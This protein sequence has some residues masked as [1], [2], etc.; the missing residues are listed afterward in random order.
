MGRF[1]DVDLRTRRSSLRCPHCG[2]MLARL[3]TPPSLGKS[4]ELNVWVCNS[5]DHTLRLEV[6]PDE[7]THK[8]AYL[9][10]I[11]HRN[12]ISRYRQMLKEQKLVALTVDMWCY[13]GYMLGGA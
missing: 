13:S 9:N 2:K 11:E 8:A 1:D 3:S 4:Y 7:D 12:A 5:I 10:G 6:S